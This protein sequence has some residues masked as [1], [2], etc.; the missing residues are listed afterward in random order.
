MI[1]LTVLKRSLIAEIQSDLPTA[2]C[3]VLST[4]ISD[5]ILRNFQTQLHPVSQAVERQ[6]SSSAIALDSIK[7]CLVAQGSSQ[8]A[9]ESALADK[10]NEVQTGLQLLR[11]SVETNATALKHTAVSILT[12]DGNESQSHKEIDPRDRMVQS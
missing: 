7:T 4:R 3:D 8:R 9:A 5:T 1:L 12:S 10:I 2:T 11:I 6:T